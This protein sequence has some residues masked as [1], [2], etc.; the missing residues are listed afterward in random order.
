[1]RSFD[2]GRR[3]DVV[4]CLFSS[5]GYLSSVTELNAAV[6]RMAAHLAPGG[7]LMVEPWLT[8]EVWRDGYLSQESHQDGDRLLVRMSHSGTDG[9]RS[10]IRM[11]YLLGDPTGI[12]HFEDQ[13]DL[14][15]FTHDEYEQALTSAGGRVTF[16]PDG[17]TGRGLYLGAFPSP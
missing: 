5:I 13:H 1:M 11:H 8:P 9:R 10:R 6:V 4:C 3:F 16:Q 14:A 12:R 17:P 2:L 7:L 15:L